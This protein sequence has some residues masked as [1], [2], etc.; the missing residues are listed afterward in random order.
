MRRSAGL[1]EGLERGVVEVGDSVRCD[2]AGMTLD[3]STRGMSVVTVTKTMYLFFTFAFN[4]V[5]G[6]R[7]DLQCFSTVLPLKPCDCYNV[8]TS[9]LL[10]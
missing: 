8:I 6:F 7:L 2:G 9:V 3:M 5:L 10:D 4:L 1:G